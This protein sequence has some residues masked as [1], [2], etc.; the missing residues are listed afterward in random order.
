MPDRAEQIDEFESLFRRAEREPYVWD[1]TPPGRITLI[2]DAETRE[3]EAVR[4]N[5]QQYFPRLPQSA[6]WKLIGGSDF[7]SVS[8]L[9]GL[10]EQEPADLVV[11]YRHLHEPS[12]VPQ[13]S[14][15]A[16]VDL[17]TQATSQPVL[18]LPGTAAAPLP[19]PAGA[20]GEVVAVTDHIAGDNRLVNQATAF[21][22]D[23]GKLYL[24][25][26][27]DEAVFNRYM[28]AVSRIPQ[29]DTD[30]VRQSL[31]EQLLKEAR[32]FIQTCREGIARH[33]PAVHTESRVLMGHHLSEYRRLTGES[34]IGLMVMNTK[35]SGQLAMHG[36]AWSISVEFVDLPLLLL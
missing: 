24:C 35:D 9:L 14:L 3:A 12:P 2:T 16:C 10:L 6:S 30:V 36:R 4:E 11:T 31:A 17:L 13:H 22:P 27:E 18:L 33:R 26:V 29:L 20:C 8:E 25:H 19:L 21:C 32:D 28:H 23:G 34:A 1:E 5:V 15:G 7:S